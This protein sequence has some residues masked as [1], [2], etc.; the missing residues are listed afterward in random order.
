[1]SMSNESP[2][3]VTGAAG[4][5]GAIG[6]NVA[7]MLLEKGHKV[8]AL[9]RR[10][11]ER[12]ESLRKLGAEVVIG[13]LTDLQ[14]LHRAVEGTQRIYFGMSISSAYLEAT[15]NIAAL[16]RHYG[17][18]AIVNMSQMTVSQ[19]NIDAS[20][21]SP[22]H[23]LHWLAEQ[24]LAWSGLPVINVRPTVFLEGF[25]LRLGAMGVR[26]NDELALPLGAA[27][28]SPIAAYDVARVVATILDNPAPHIGKIYNLTGPES[29][30]VEQHARAFS[31]ALGRTI[32]YRDV[33]V[34][35]WTEKLREFGVPAHLLSH[36]AVMADL[37]A[38]GRYDRITDDV[39]KLTGQK[40]M[41]TAEFVKAHAADFT[42]S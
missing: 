31:E 34:A 25:F 30:D 26:D 40:P 27:R 19:M 6:R 32:R 14:S 15:A 21:D 3:L 17:V 33:P 4:D 10:E 11:D 42:R 24:V 16:A 28:T 29:V 35:A 20:T 39:F 1:M 12:A 36:L 18:E 13:D 22:Q 23:K 8:R 38:Q 9:V 41:S 5:V 7:T 2:I 37:H